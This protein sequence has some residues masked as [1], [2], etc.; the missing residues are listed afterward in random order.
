MAPEKKYMDEREA[1]DRAED[2]LRRSGASKEIAR[3]LADA[4]VGRVLDK[5]AQPPGAK[6]R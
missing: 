6:R 3:K 4:S 2:A 1:T 5:F